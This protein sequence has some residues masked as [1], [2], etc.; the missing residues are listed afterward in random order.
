MFLYGFSENVGATIT[1]ASKVYDAFK[2]VDKPQEKLSTIDTMQGFINEHINSNSNIGDHDVVDL[3][4]IGGVYTL[5]TALTIKKNVRLISIGV[6]ELKV[7]ESTLFPSKRHIITIEQS[8]INSIKG[9]SFT[10]NI[11]GGVGVGILNALTTK[12]ETEILVEDCHFITNKVKTFYIAGYDKVTFKNIHYNDNKRT[13]TTGGVPITTSNCKSV[14]FDGCTILKNTNTLQ[15]F[16]YFDKFTY[17]AIVDMVRCRL[18]LTNTYNLFH[19]SGSNINSFVV[20]FKNTLIHNTGYNLNTYRTRMNYTIY[21]FDG[22]DE[23]YNNN[24]V[25]NGS[26]FRSLASTGWVHIKVKDVDL[27]GTI[28]YSEPT[29]TYITDVGNIKSIA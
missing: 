28:I 6:T 7:N 9:F 20:N 26:L 21:R 3:Y 18:T 22:I 29:S 11:V 27:I 14:I 13:S 19:N 1:K 12:T 5:T 23:S 17:P 10:N 24:A 25:I 4:I 15:G 2:I 8:R 16:A